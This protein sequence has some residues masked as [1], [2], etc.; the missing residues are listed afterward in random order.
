MKRVLLFIGT[1][2]AFG[3]VHFE[4]SKYMH[5]RGIVCDVLDWGKSYKRDEMAMMASYYDY[6]Y[7][8]PGETWPLTD[9]YGIAHEKIVVVAHGEYDLHHVVN[10]RPPEE[11]ERFAEYA[12]ISE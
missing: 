9:N 10:T 3:S 4:L 1:G 2:W 8:V 11:I 6:F 5:A 7:G 12:V